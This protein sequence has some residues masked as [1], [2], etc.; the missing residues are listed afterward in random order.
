MSLRSNIA[1]YSIAY[2]CG[3]IALLAL[4]QASAGAGAQT[5]GSRPLYELYTQICDDVRPQSQL[6]A[7]LGCFALRDDPDLVKT[8]IE[9]YTHS[10][11][12]S[13]DRACEVSRDSDRTKLILE[14]GIR[15]NCLRTMPA[16]GGDHDQW[17]NVTYAALKA[18][19]DCLL[20]GFE[21][22]GVR[23]RSSSKV[24]RS[25][26]VVVM[27]YSQSQEATWHTDIGTVP[28]EP[29][30]QSRLTDAIGHSCASF[31]EHADQ[32]AVD[33]RGAFIRWIHAQITEL[34]VPL[35]DEEVSALPI[36]RAHAA[37]GVRN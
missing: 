3:M 8:E 25:S 32:A 30:F 14:L 17:S 18:P 24:N 27:R 10:L 11:C 33:I 6:D 37:I 35:N 22:V 2:L 13:F 15:A 12:S 36:I 9:Y 7:A 34:I 23:I 26:I 20:L 28:S 21:I 16:C 5:P 19:A 4:S 29:D 31:R 1:R